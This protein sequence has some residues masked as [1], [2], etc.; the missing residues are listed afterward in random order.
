MIHV[1]VA[2]VGFVTFCTNVVQP[3]EQRFE[4]VK[5][6]ESLNIGRL[7]RRFRFWPASGIFL[8]GVVR[9]SIF[10]V[11]TGGCIVEKLV[12][13]LSGILGYNRRSL[14]HSGRTEIPAEYRR[15]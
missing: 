11:C 7:N 8:S 6:L 4:L 1:E 15:S 3:S 5:I 10:D 13:R 9:R 12:I 14:C 2:I